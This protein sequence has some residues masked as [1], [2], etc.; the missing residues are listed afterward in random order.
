MMFLVSQP[1]HTALPDFSDLEQKPALFRYKGWSINPQ[2]VDGQLW[3]RWQ[4]PED[5]FSRYGC[6]TTKASLFSTVKYVQSLID[7]II[8]LEENTPLAPEKN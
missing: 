7:M 6:P 4:H 5:S 2:L 8:N 3:L 1:Q